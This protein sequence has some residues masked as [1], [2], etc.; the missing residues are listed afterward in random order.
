MA[1]IPEDECA[2]EG[3]EEYDDTYPEDDW[4]A[5][6]APE[7][8]SI[9]EADECEDE[10]VFGV[11]YYKVPPSGML[12]EC[13][14]WLT[15][16]EAFLEEHDKQNASSDPEYQTALIGYQEAR[17]ALRNARLAREF[18]PVVVPAGAFFRKTRQPK[19]KPK[20]QR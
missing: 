18:Y 14:N 4:A 11:E 9:L 12:D 17:A 8:E 5:H 6:V 3:E 10:E 13:G 1:N 2:W 20:R 19:G 15:S 7:H 16:D